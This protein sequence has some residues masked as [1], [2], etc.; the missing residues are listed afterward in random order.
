MNNGLIRPPPEPPDSGDDESPGLQAPEGYA[1]LASFPSAKAAHEH[2]L[3]VLA[4][5]LAYWIG[6][7][8]GAYHLFVPEA[9]LERIKDQIGRYEKES[10][11]R[12]RYVFEWREEQFSLK[13]LFVVCVLLCV[14]SILQFIFPKIDNAAIN[15]AHAVIR[16][17]EWWRVITALT[18]HDGI[19]HLLI[20]C[21][22]FLLYGAIA[23]AL[24]GWGWML[25]FSILGGA[26]G[27]FLTAWTYYPATHY[28]LGASTAV[29][30]VIGLL[31]SAM[32]V[33]RRANGEAFW[34][35]IV[36]AI[37][38]AMAGLVITGAASSSAPENIDH[39]AH[40]MGFLSGFTLGL[41]AGLV[42]RWRGV[43]GRNQK[44][45]A[46][47]AFAL[48]AIAWLRCMRELV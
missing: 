22:V 23:N 5:Q 24:F 48:L 43:L 20:N 14:F 26:V 16:D 6:H 28:S 37:A 19:F 11:G 30:A 17:H 41:G 13:P 15:D 4:M 32:L 39:L 10:V 9:D 29:Y 7:Q 25:L 8:E 42:K 35:K 40:W 46:L 47:I 44:I 34:K 27:N 3:I 21:F 45:P 36:I 18:L 1:L 2:G 12:R 38:A 31:C 33:A